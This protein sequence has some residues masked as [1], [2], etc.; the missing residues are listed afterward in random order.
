MAALFLALVWPL[1]GL[2]AGSFAAHMGQ[3]V[4]LMVLA[5]PLLVLGRPVGPFIWA[6]PPA[7]R[8][9]LHTAWRASGWPMW[10]LL[11]QLATATLLHAAAIW[12]WHAP[13]AFDAVLE[14]DVLHA[15]EHASFL[16]TALL[17][18]EAALHRARSVPMGYGA[19]AF[20]VF[21]TLVHGGM[22]GAILT[23]APA[24]LY[25]ARGP[26]VFGLSPL[27]DQQL[28]GLI[29]WV[30]GGMVYLCAGLL[31]IGL[32]LEQSAREPV[33][34]GHISARGARFGADKGGA[35]GNLAC[36]RDRI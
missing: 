11:T 26:A 19:G 9:G 25:T 23:F 29:M 15:L 17:F 10:R 20:W 18:W 13:A 33:L 35:R 7:W 4:I 16:V 22:L 2:S 8:H 1:D 14:S 32:W 21:V 6:L 12:A 31:L 24:P 3:H 27:E 5:A 36:G 30:P 34:A 28:A